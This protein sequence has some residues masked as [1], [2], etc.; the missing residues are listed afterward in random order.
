VIKNTMIK[1]EWTP[2]REFY[3]CVFERRSRE[4]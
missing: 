1:M 4:R 3:E 2:F